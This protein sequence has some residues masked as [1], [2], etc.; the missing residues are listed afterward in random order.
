MADTAITI[1]KIRTSIEN[2]AERLAGYTNKYNVLYSDIAFGSGATDTVTLT[3]GTTAALWVV[4]SAIANV[5]TAFAG[6]GAMTI[7]VGTSG[8]AN[9][10]IAATSILSAGLIQPTNGAGAVNTPASST[11]TSAATMKAVFTNA[12]SGSPSALSAG[13]LDIYVEHIDLS[14]L[15]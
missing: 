1:S 5:T 2:N 11:S 14:R 7:Q 8:T 13:A 10:F 3:L 15:T 12:T 6:T 9:A 4:K